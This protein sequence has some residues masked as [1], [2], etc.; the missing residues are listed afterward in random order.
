MN[1]I[2]LE[3]QHWKD[4][5]KGETAWILGS[6][7]S[8]DELNPSKVRGAYSFALNLTILMEDYRQ[9]WWVC[10]DGRCMMKWCHL[11]RVSLSKMALL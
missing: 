7:P 6:G 4:C 9:S 8:L 5:Y 10:R 1:P 2:E 3:I 11:S